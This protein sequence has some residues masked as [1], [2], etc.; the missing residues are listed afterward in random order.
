MSEHEVLLDIDRGKRL[1]LEEAIFCR[2]KSTA[3]IDVILARIDEAGRACLLT[4]LSRAQL[5]G[6]AVRFRASIDYDETSKTAFFRHSPQAA[7]A[8]EIGI[9]TAGSSDVPVARE[10]QRTLEYFGVTAFTAFDVGVA[11][12]WRLLDRIDELRELPIVIAVAGM[13]AALPSVLGG[14]YPG[15]IVPCQPRWAMG[16]RPVA[17]PR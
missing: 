1:G 6:V 3:Q 13:D 10:A 17:Q 9:V 15:L 12:L 8:P 2:H 11:G 5:D 14:L 4:H 7:A 16:S